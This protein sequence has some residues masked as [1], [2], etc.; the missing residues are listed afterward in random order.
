MKLAGRRTIT[1]RATAVLTALRSDR[2]AQPEALTLAY[3][4][5]VR[6]L[7]AVITALNEQVKV[8]EQQVREH[9]VQIRPRLRETTPP[10]H[11][12]MRVR[13]ADRRLGATGRWRACDG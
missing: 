11:D 13:H 10:T 2:L 4:A 8:L 6:S 5:T 3:A 9:G 1:E 12:G 7:I